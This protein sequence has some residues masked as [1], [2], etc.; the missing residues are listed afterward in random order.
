MRDLNTIATQC[1]FVMKVISGSTLE[2]DNISLIKFFIKMKRQLTSILLFSALLMG[3]ASTF[4]SCTDHESDAAY[5]VTGS[6]ADQLNKQAQNLQ[7]QVDAIKGILNGGESGKPLQE[8]VDDLKTNLGQKETELKT[9][10]E[11]KNNATST[12]LKQLIDTKISNVNKDI[13]GLKRDI[14][15]AKDDI[16]RLKTQVGETEGKINAAKQA[17]I[18]AAK[19]YTDEKVNA[20]IAKAETE[21]GQQVAELKTLI[22]NCKTESKAYTDEQIAAMKEITNGLEQQQAEY[23]KSIQQLFALHADVMDKLNQDSILLAQVQKGQTNLQTAVSELNTK[24]EAKVDTADFNAVKAQVDKNKALS[25][26]NEAAIN[27]IKAQMVDFV[28]KTELDNKASELKTAFEAADTALKEKIDAEV[29]KLN[30]QLNKL[31]NTMINMLTGI[32]LQATESPITGYENFSFLG[33]EAH[34]LGTYY[35][36]AT[37]PANLGDCTINK[38]QPLI[39]ETSGE[40]AGVVYA[41]LNPSNV[42][43]T[44]CTLKIVDSQGNEAPFTATVVK[45][46]RVLKYGISRAGKSNLYAIKINLNK[47]NL[48]AAKT[49]TSSDAA[50]LKDVAKNVLDKL[51]QP[52]TTRL[53]IGDAA[54]TIAKTFNNRL[55]AYALQA[56]QD[57]YDANNVKH[58]RTITSKLSLAATA[59]KPVSYNFLKDN[60]TLKNLDLPS[61]PTIQS[62]LNFNDYKFN[63]TPIAGMGTVKTSVTLKGMPDLDNIKVTINGEV[64]AP[65][66]NVDKA[67]IKFGQ[68]T[69][70]GTVDENGKVTVN[71]GDLEK[72]TTADVKVSIDN[73]KINPDDVKVTLD[74]SAKKDMTYDVEIPMDE[75]NKIIDN[76]NSQV[77]NMIGNVNGIVD[78]VQNYAEIIDGRYI[79]GINKFIQKFENLLRKSNSLLQPAMFYVTSNG[80][81][82]QLAREK[83]GASYLKLQ[84]GKASTVFVASSYSG[85]ILAPAYKKYVHVTD[86]PKGAHV[87][88]ANLD[89]VIDGNLHKIGFE[90]DKEGTY[91]ITYEAVDY[92][93]VKAAKKKFY[94]KVVK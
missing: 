81:W 20:A 62:K 52:S 28:T 88:G 76:I 41:T 10:I 73:I 4:V 35:G 14:A 26:A 48:D 75:F 30:E 16:E 19:G 65:E 67:T 13:E 66:V 69:L 45:S 92:S 94:V 53:N 43:F 6:I 32:E 46:N 54:T 74:T 47:E 31:F 11:Q 58:T 68:T 39:D 90:A 72:N 18:E 7:N 21:L 24:L 80:S 5:E 12:E 29:K 71:L 49:W 51:R 15:T 3:G 63:W 82:N 22:E 59:I 2:L 84:G 27:S 55:T 8:Q 87:T 91:E 33:A 42:D 17:A 85:E 36:T 34:I 40:N 89:K 78:K 93:G 37:V 9:L 50:A 61:F 1:Y 23:A 60:A 79:A 44:N 56:E 83:E 70:Y 25:E 86:A 57:Y 38:N 64:K 77:G